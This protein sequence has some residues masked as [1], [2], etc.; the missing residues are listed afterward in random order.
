MGVLAKITAVILI[1]VGLFVMLSGVVAGVT[2]LFRGGMMNPGFNNP[3]M[4]TMPQGFLSGISLLVGAAIF[5]QGLMLAAVGEA[6]FLIAN[7]AHN[8]GL[9]GPRPG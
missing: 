4:P 3:F 2:G 8:T 5:G 6:L 7:I 9:T 1:I